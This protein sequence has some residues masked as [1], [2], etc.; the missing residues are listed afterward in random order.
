VVRKKEVVLFIFMKFVS[1]N[2]QK[3]IF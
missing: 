3:N 2:E 1:K